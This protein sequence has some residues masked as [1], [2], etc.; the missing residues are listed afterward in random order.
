[1]NKKNSIHKK[2]DHSPED[3]ARRKALREKL[4][5]EKPAPEELA[6]AGYGEPIPQGVVLDTM[7]LLGMLRKA[8][9][10]AGLTLADMAGRTGMDVAALS[11][12]ETG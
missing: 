6:S 11:R 7:R 8:R 3:K 1:M 4:Q 12:L 10:A 2:I 5:R 9:E